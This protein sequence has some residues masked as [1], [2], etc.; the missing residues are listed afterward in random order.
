MAQNPGLVR[1]Q[2]A[3][4]RRRDGDDCWLCLDPIDFSISDKN[5]PL[6]YSRDHLRP[7][8][9]GGSNELANLRLAHRECNRKRGCQ[10]D[11]NSGRQR[12][13]PQSL[14]A[15]KARGQRYREVS[16]DDRMSARQPAGGR[17]LYLGEEPLL[18]CA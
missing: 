7:R 11:G 17:V 16:W 18:P 1:R 14:E 8:V 12:D 10:W 15:R 9:A 4:L 5:D 3:A 13:S 6:H 2:V